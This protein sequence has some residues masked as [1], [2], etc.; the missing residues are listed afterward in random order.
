MGAR[1]AVRMAEFTAMRGASVSP[2]SEDLASKSIIGVR[3]HDE[4]MLQ[5]MGDLLG[6]LTG[7]EDDKEVAHQVASLLVRLGGLGLRSAAEW[8]R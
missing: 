3:R 1:L 4:E 8:R 7:G 6:G 2:P 5:A